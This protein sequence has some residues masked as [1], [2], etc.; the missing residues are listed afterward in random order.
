MRR[1]IILI[2]FLL[3][4]VQLFAQTQYD[5]YEGKDAYGGVDT[6][7]TGLKI[8]GIIVL[9]VVVILAI[10]AIYGYFAGWFS[11]NDNRDIPTNTNHI[12]KKDSKSVNDIYSKLLDVVIVTGKTIEAFYTCTDGSK[13][14]SKYWYEIESI[15]YNYNL[16]V[17]ESSVDTHI[18]LCEYHGNSIEECDVILDSVARVTIKYWIVKQDNFEPGYLH[19]REIRPCKVRLYDFKKI[20]YD[21]M[22]FVQ[23]PNVAMKPLAN[24]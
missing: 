5:Y 16:D 1:L 18:S 22:Y 23:N 12:P 20:D 7:I 24:Y 19:F 14:K 9:A 15:K 17:K 6:A 10:A 13:I 2:S 3:T 11:H 4:A 21:D 8:I